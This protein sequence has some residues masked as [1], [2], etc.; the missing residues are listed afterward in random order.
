MNDPHIHAQFR[1][2]NISWKE[3][4]DPYGSKQNSS[5]YFSYGTNNWLIRALLYSHNET[6]KIF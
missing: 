4:Q 2:E 3:E 5:E 1:L 6:R